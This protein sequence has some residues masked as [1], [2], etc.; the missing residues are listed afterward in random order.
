MEVLKAIFGILWL[1]VVC[2]G[3]IVIVDSIKESWKI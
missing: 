1:V 3:V 2:V